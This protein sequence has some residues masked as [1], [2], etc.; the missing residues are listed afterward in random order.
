MG[1]NRNR[2]FAKRKRELEKKE[3]A[4][5][6]RARKRSRGPGGEV[7]IAE[8][9]P[10]MD[11]KPS[12]EEVMRAVELAMNPGNK[13][14]R[15]SRRPSFGTRLFVGNVSSTADEHDL[16]RLFLEAGF[17]VSDAVIPRDR[18]TGEPRGFAFIELAKASDA[19]KA[20]EAMDGASFH[21]RA[22]RV[23]AADRR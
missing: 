23:N 22:L 10:A 5:R 17:E 1:S 4:D 6:K 9:G 13:G 19:A 18:S 14:A 15:E 7:E 12:D 20:I 16:R 11:N 2:R 3:R 8:T 21:S